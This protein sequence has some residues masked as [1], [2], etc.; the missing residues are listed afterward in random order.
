MRDAVLCVGIR[1]V[2]CHSF[3]IIRGIT[4]GNAVMDA[5]EHGHIIASVSEYYH[6]VV[7]NS[8]MAA[9][10]KQRL[11]LVAAFLGQLQIQ[12]P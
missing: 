11:S 8:Q 9:Q 4:H 12:I 6:L 7:R 5:A 10:P 2:S 1:A 3:H